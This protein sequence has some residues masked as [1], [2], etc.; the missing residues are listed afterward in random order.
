MWHSLTAA[1]ES[2]HFPDHCDPLLLKAVKFPKLT[3]EAVKRRPVRLGGN[4]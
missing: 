3:G 1:H 4:R 2:H